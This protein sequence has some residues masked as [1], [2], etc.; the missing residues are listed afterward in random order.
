MPK[1][2]VLDMELPHMNQ[3]YIDKLGTYLLLNLRMGYR[4]AQFVAQNLK[5]LTYL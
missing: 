2:T 4:G 5:N 1:L 3:L